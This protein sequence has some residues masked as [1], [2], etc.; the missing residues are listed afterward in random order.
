[1]VALVA[2]FALFDWNWLKRPLAAQISAM[3]GRSFSIDGNLD[4]DLGRVITV[5]A[6]GLRL[7]NADGAA[8][9]QMASLEQLE[10]A[11]ALWPLMRGDLELPRIHLQQPRVLL[12]RNARGEG[13]WDFMQDDET[14]DED[15]APPRVGLLTIADG[16]LRLHEPTLK[17]DL[18]LDFHS[19]EVSA[20]DAAAPIIAR[21]EGRY[22][23]QPFELAARVDSP[24][25]LQVADPL[26]RIDLRARAG[27]TKAR[28]AGTLLSPLQLRDFDLD[29]ALAGDDLAALYPLL[30][31][32]LPQT[33]PYALKGRIGRDGVAWHYRDFTG[34]V[35][36]SDL[37]GSVSI[38]V[39]GDRPHFVAKLES[40]RLGID[41]LG[42]FVGAIP[43]A[44]AGDIASAARAENPRVLPDR[45]YDLAKLRAMDADVQLRVAALQA[46][47]LPLES[48]NVHLH[49]DDGLL[50]LD[51]LTVGV[52][53]GTMRGTL[54]LNARD[55]LIAVEA[56][57]QAREVQLPKL[58]P[59]AEIMEQ[60]VGRIG[61]TINLR[62]RGN[63]VAQMLA[64]A[65]GDV[66]VAM[67]PGR[68][69]A[70]LVELAGLDVAEGL[71]YL[72]GKDRNIALHCAYADFV[73]K[74][75]VMETRAFAIDTSDTALHG[76]G[77]IDL[78]QEKLALR[79]IPQPKD[80]SLLSLR[81]PLT[82]GGTFKSPKVRPEIGP[83]ALRSAVAA[84]L[85][86]IAP[87]AALLALIETGP[88]QDIECSSTH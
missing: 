76:E 21:G 37:A 19:G 61:A 67:G 40:K 73:V 8:E 48:M 52:A 55:N 81:V 38:D 71:R 36:D 72:I 5:R 39:S 17:T 69:S 60:A 1:M 65:D 14:P 7:A 44:G 68:V 16:E 83:L 2:F 4:V 22:R 32:A 50:K 18:R 30:G 51:P 23:G 84:G 59:G 6:E 85:F 27:A 42:G 29:F 3:T 86:A 70:L 35:G 12:E 10:L 82:I 45:P 53:G 66:G 88:G 43:S 41:D 25:A 31:V 79:L 26:Y 49:L 63:S 78:S 58:V 11:V 75:G 64:Q 74:R 28:L 20:D 13:N 47:G 62:A 54:Q 15:R 24:L 80:R 56:A 34:R 33:P 87:P 77:R 9:P 46:P 57:V